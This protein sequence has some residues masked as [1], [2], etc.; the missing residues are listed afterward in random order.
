MSF[1]SSG[2]LHIEHTDAS[3]S[4]AE[5]L[6]NPDLSI[7]SCVYIEKEEGKLCGE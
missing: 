7:R 1:D 6:V 2:I 3:G 4:R 5:V